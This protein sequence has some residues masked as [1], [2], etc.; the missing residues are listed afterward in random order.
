VT[1]TFTG[2]TSG[3]VTGIT[4]TNGIVVLKSTSLKTSTGQ[5][6]FNISGVTLSGGNPAGATTSFTPGCEL[7]SATMPIG[8]DLTTDLSV[9][10]NPV[11][12]K[13]RIAYSVAQD[14]PVRIAIYNNLGQPLTIL[15]NEYL[16]EGNYSTAWSATGYQEGVYICRMT[17]GNQVISKTFILKK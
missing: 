14:G 5:W 13:A 4:G 15:V 17:N 11:K 6:C 16:E 8:T 3:T 9:Y 12:G 2:P 1:A 7:K 10:P